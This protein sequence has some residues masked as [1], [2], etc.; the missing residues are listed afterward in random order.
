MFPVH[1]NIFLTSLVIA[2]RF[3]FLSANKIPKPFPHFL[4]MSWNPLRKFC[5]LLFDFYTRIKFFVPSRGLVIIYVY[6]FHCD[7]WSFLGIRLREEICINHGKEGRIYCS[8]NDLMK[9]YHCAFKAFDKN[10]ILFLKIL[11]S[12]FK[13]GRT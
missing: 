4:T 3:L 12:Y 1:R 6:K 9:L 7:K 5:Y 8:Q 13:E 11:H 2:E 10:R